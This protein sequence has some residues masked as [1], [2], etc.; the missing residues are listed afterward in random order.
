MRLRIEGLA[1]GSRLAVDVLNARRLD[2]PPD[3]TPLGIPGAV[4]P[5]TFGDR[6]Q[7]AQRMVLRVGTAYA[8]D[9]FVHARDGR[10]IGAA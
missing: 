5:Y 6:D 10:R 4:A 2:D 7:R 1:L 3:V 8:F 9:E